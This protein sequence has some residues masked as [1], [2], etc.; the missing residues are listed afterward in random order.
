MPSGNKEFEDELTFLKDLIFEAGECALKYF[1]SGVDVIQKQD[2]SPVTVADKEIEAL[3]RLEI[4]KRYPGDAILGE[5]QEE[6]LSK[7]SSRRWI[8]D[9]I[10]GT[11]NFCRGIPTFSI[12]AALEDCGEVRVGAVYNPVLKDL[13]YAASGMGAY[14]NDSQLFVSEVGSL[15]QALI[16]FGGPKRFV[17]HGYWSKLEGLINKSY[18]HRGYGD[19]L[20]FAYVFEG[21]SEANIEV[22]LKPWDLAPMKILV[23]ESGGVFQDFDG[24]KSIYHGSCIVSNRV[25]AG[26]LLD[27]FFMG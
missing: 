24:G 13:Y 3:I 18:Q 15:D 4:E 20:G 14:K 22:A 17:E 1:S 21:L 12:L 5:E 27:C 11:M 10:D 19:Y 26:D 23:E 9:P 25:L 6:K 16:S 2:G 8:I 7:D